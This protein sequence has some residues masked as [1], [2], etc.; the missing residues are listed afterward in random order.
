MMDSQDSNRPECRTAL[1]ARELSRYNVD[2]AAISETR[3][4][5]EGQLTKHGAGYTFLWKGK[6][7][8]EHRIQG[9]G[10][11]INNS[12]VHQLTELPV[13]INDCLITLRVPLTN[14]CY[15]VFISVYAPTLDAEDSEKE[16]FYAS[17]NRVLAAVPNK[18]KKTNVQCFKN[19]ESRLKLRSCFERKLMD[20]SIGHGCISAQ[21]EAL[22]T[23]I[24]SACAE[25]VGYTSKKHQDWF[26]DNDSQIQEL[27]DRKCAAFVDWQNNP[28]S[29]AK[30][31]LY[32]QLRAKTQHK[33]CMMK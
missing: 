22:K 11:A 6:P 2:I 15:A 21:W 17:L 19:K 20:L 10:F 7:A 18:D 3:L 4:P 13:G 32:H 1:V 14:F 31:E 24:I 30:K 9:V 12:L 27:I 33:I 16:M 28:Q 5:A 29:L 25:T 8:E 26:D 23:A